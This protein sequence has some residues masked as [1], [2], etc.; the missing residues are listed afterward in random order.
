M[1]WPLVLLALFIILTEII[2]FTVAKDSYEFGTSFFAK[3]CSSML[4]S[5]IVVFFTVGFP[6][7]IAYAPRDNE[8]PVY[9]PVAYLWYYGT[10]LAIGLFFG[11]NYIISKFAFRDK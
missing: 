8:L 7:L 6:T 11:V 3:K 9:G 1:I 2:F 4:I 10:F 5:L